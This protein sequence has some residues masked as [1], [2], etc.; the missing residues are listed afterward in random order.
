VLLGSGQD[1]E[2]TSA[3]ASGEFRP[4]APPDRTGG[5]D[6]LE[7]LLR[8][9]RPAIE[10]YVRSRART[11]DD[12]DDLVQ[13]VLLKA[14]RHFGDFREEC[15]FSQWLLR[16]AINEVKNY[17][18]RLAGERIESTDAW[19]EENPAALQQSPSQACPTLHADDSMV[20]ERLLEAMHCV[21]GEDE[22]NVISMVY[23]G[24]SFEEIAAVLEMKSATVRSHFLRGRAKL[25]AHLVANEPDL[26]GG[27]EAIRAAAERAACSDAGDALDM[28]E[29]EAL[30]AN[31]ANSTV[32]RSA[33]VKIAR[34]LPMPILV[35]A[36]MEATWIL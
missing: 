17:Y 31:D 11:R 9:E 34:H 33:C 14:A 26:V 3:R 27:A 30:E 5:T 1:S 16:I 4:K 35:F 6:A 15:P 29:R 25:L 2:G 18:R 10:R 24:E 23:Q 12:A 8:R 28:A 36:A 22:T 19:E 20:A 32:F 7:D 21:C 13:N